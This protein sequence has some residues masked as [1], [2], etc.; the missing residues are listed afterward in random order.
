M[1]MHLF[2]NRR[3]FRAGELTYGIPR[4]QSNFAVQPGIVDAAVANDR[5]AK[6]AKAAFMGAIANC[7]LYLRLSQRFSEKIRREA[8]VGLMNIS[9]SQQFLTD[10]SSKP[11]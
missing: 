2:G 7:S 10:L 5:L 9:L 11:Q 8:N 6:F 1:P 4:H 3:H